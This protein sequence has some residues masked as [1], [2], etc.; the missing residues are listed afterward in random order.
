[1]LNIIT[2]QKNLGLKPQLD[3]TMTTRRLDF[4][5]LVFPDG[6]KIVDQLDYSYIV[7]MNAEL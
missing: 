5:I 3:T 4:K 7:G 2:H 1:M 6:N